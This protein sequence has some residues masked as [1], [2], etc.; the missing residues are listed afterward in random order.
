MAHKR[1]VALNGS[2]TTSLTLHSNG[3]TQDAMA[4]PVGNLEMRRT[5]FTIRTRK[6]SHLRPEKDRPQM[7]T[8]Y[9]P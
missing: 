1:S 7:G 9:V 3:R 4:H 6:A 8:L 2:H 5:G